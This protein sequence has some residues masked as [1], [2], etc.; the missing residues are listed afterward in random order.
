MHGAVKEY[1]DAGQGHEMTLDMLL[2]RLK[3][4]NQMEQFFGPISDDSYDPRVSAFY[5]LVMSLFLLLSFLLS[6]VL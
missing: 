6:L 1:F 3:A 5:V 2:N 4:Q